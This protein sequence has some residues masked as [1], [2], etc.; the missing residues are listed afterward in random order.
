MISIDVNSG[1]AKSSKD[2]ESMAFSTNLEAAVEAARQLRLRDLGGLVV[3]DFIDMR[4]KKHIRAIEKTLREELKKDRAKTDV[5]SI[6]KFGLLELSRQRLRPSIESK[7]Y[8]PCNHCLGRGTVIG[9][10]AA[11]LSFMRRIHKGLIKSGISSVV[12]TLPVEVADY[13]LN[14]KR[15]ELVELEDRYSISIL[16][17]GDLSMPPGGG[18][19]EFKTED[20][21]NK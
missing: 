9:P 17:K 12:A 7:S 11:A 5:A 8:V 16:V 13:I 10:G 2:V 4:D 21:G 14:K 3:I 6:S 20:T 19:L 18:N 15:H 1:R